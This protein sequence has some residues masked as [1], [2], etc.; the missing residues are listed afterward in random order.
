MRVTQGA[1]T[2]VDV[3]C[4]MLLDQTEW[5]KDCEWR[6]NVVSSVMGQ[7]VLIWPQLVQYTP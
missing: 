5:V 2:D 4:G 7:T 3:L 6:R 1:H